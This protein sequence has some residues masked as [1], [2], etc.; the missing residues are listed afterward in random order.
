MKRKETIYKGL[1]FIDVYYVDQT[2]TSPDFF[3]I[4]EFPTQLTA[5]KNLIKLK[6]HPDNLAVNSF[7]NVEILDFNGDPIYHEIVNYIDDDRSRIIAIYI[8]SETAPGDCT[9]TLL[10]EATN[11][12]IDWQGRGNV[13]WSRTVSVNPTVANS[14]EIIFE[15]L[16]TVNITEIHEDRPI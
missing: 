14:S 7:L 4:T 13:K 10:A 1:Q 5:G 6:G 2:L 3:Q 11:V 16:P 12:P 8:Y 15:T 9:I